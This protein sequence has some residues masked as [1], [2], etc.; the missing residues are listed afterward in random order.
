[1]TRRVAIISH[2]GSYVG[3]HLAR[4][5]AREHDLVVGDPA[6]G[7]LYEL[8]SKGAAVEVVENVSDLSTSGASERLV[9]AARNRFGRVDAAAF[10]GGGIMEGAFVQSSIDDLREALIRCVEAPYNFLRAIVPVMLEQGSGQILV[11]TSAYGARPTPGTPLYSTARA[12]ANMLVRNVAAEIVDKG[13]QVNA[14]GPNWMD[15]PEF[16]EAFRA[17]DPGGRAR[18]EAMVPMGRLAQMDELAHFAMAFIDGTSRFVTG[19]YVPFAG[20]WA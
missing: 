1:M 2:T 8:E 13:V 4:L 6:V 11:L 5:L 17:Q 3:P 20:G 7:L 9:D 19:Q 15:C 12:A 14:I 10:F 18:L 16:F